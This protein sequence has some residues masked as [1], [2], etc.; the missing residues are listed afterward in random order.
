M[1][2]REWLRW[3]RGWRERRKWRIFDPDPRPWNQRVADSRT[4][5]PECGYPLG[6]GPCTKPRGH[7]DSHRCSR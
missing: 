5:P 1:R 4:L 6:L 7:T 3:A 2:V